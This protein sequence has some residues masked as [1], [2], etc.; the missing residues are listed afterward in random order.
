MLALLA[1]ALLLSGCGSSAGSASS[2]AAYHSAPTAEMVD[3]EEAG[4]GMEFAADASYFPSEPAAAPAT[5]TSVENVEN[6]SSD[7]KLIKTVNVSAETANLYRFDLYL[8]EQVAALGGYI[9]SSEKYSN[10]ST[11]D[12]LYEYIE[13]GKELTREEIEERSRWTNAYYNIRIPAAN[14]DGFVREIDDK[15]NITSQ[16]NNIEDVTLRYVDMQSKKNALRAEEKRLGELLEEAITIE[17]VLAIEDKLTDIRYELESI[18]SQLR[19]LEN[20][21]DYGT[22]HLDVH[23]VNRFTRIEQPRSAAERIAR[24]FAQS[25]S[26]VTYGLK[27]FGIWFVIHIPY[28]LLLLAFGLVVFLIVR[29]LLRL[30]KGAPARRER[31]RQRRE[32]ERAARLARKQQQQQQKQQQQGPPQEPGQGGV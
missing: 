14:L 21:I 16:S 24:G 9:E 26:D 29:L 22:L 19:V 15:A 25:V 28:F 18:E 17:E 6:P 27:E 5:G 3:Y 20:Q 31:K 13:D 2:S 8:T 11:E 10:N 32:Q 23:Q 12:A 4:Y 7:R 30:D 1:G